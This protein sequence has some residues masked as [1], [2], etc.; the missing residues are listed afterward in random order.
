MIWAS[1]ERRVASWS[2]SATVKRDLAAVRATSHGTIT[3]RATGET[4]PAHLRKLL[5]LEGTGAVHVPAGAARRGLLRHLA[6]PPPG[7]G[8]VPHPLAVAKHDAARATQMSPCPYR[9]R[10]GRRRR[11]PNRPC[12]CSRVAVTAGYHGFGPPMH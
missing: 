11:S 4:L 8:Y 2:A 7:F 1:L 9:G 10:A 5:V 12:A 6:S 3:I